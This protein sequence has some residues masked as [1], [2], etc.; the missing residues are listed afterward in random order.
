MRFGLLWNRRARIA[1]LRRHWCCT[2]G[3]GAVSLWMTKFCCES[4]HRLMLR[5]LAEA[6]TSV[7]CQAAFTCAAFHPQNYS[8][9]LMTY[10]GSKDR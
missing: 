8:A 10:E 3:S 4:L 6:A 5:A 9:L 2:S 7:V 1:A